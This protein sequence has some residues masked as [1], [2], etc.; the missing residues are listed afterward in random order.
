MLTYDPNADTLSTPIEEPRETTP[1]GPPTG[2]LKP[3]PEKKIDESQMADFSSPIEDVLPGPGQLLQD[4]VQGSAYARPPPRTVSNATPP[5]SHSS[6]NPLGL[7]DDQYA[8]ALGGVAAVV[9]FSKPV[10]GK[11]STMV[12]KFLGENGEV[13]L[14]GLIVTALIA[15]ILFYFAR[16]YINP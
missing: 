16:K 10:Q 5:A 1:T 11:L 7:T 12:P 8:A 2:L 13:S 14:T 9:A 4:E 6:K 3:E 15:A